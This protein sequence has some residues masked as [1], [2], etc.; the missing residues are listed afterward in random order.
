MRTMPHVVKGINAFFWSLGIPN[1]VMPFAIG[2]GVTIWI[3]RP[4]KE[5]ERW[6]KI[7][8]AQAE[9]GELAVPLDFD[10]VCNG[11]PE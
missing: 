5:K 3:K 8:V 6:E 9:A 10:L 4:P 7:L 1:Q 11:E 2:P